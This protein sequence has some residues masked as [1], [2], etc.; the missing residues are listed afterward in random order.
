MSKFR[1]KKGLDLP[2][3]GSPKQEITKTIKTKKVALLGDDYVGMK[4]TMLVSIGDKVKLGQ[5]LF[6][7]KKT[8]SVKY[9]APASGEVLQVNRGEKRAFKSIVIEVQGTEEETFKSFAENELTSLNTD[10][11]KSILNNS[12]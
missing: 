6:T 1:I 9:T 4:P 7:D 2:I 5:V 8:P 3:T 12:V 10:V 11:I